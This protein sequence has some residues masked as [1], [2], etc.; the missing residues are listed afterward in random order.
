[1]KPDAWMDSNGVSYTNKVSAEYYGCSTPLYSLATIK[2]W[3]EE[4]I[5][6]DVFQ[7]GVNCPGSFEDTYRTMLSQ[8]L[9]ELE[10]P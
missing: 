5:S 9:A 1:M 6:A 4:E 2:A 10:Q 3:L 7:A 8:K